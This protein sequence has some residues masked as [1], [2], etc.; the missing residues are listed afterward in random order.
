MTHGTDQPG[1]Q[2]SPENIPEPIRDLLTAVLDAIDLPYPAT[3]GFTKVHDELL[4]ARV[5]HARLAVRSVLKNGAD[6]D[7]GPAWNANYLRERLAE[8]P[9]TG[10]VTTDQARAALDEGKTWS[11]AVA[12]PDKQAVAQ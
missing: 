11:E 1:P 2:P 8:H 5:V 4:A 3:I 6:G 10:Y 9:V 12:L 7:L